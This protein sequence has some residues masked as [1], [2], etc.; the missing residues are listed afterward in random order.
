MEIVKK[1]GRSLVSPNLS[2]T[3]QATSE[4]LKTQEGYI[5]LDQQQKNIKIAHSLP[6]IQL[7]RLLETDPTSPGRSNLRTT[8]RHKLD[9]IGVAKIVRRILFKL[10]HKSK[11]SISIENLKPLIAEVHE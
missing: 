8:V 1:I 11:E 3:H 5:P 9:Y 10:Q 6:P 2:D 4:L 7:R